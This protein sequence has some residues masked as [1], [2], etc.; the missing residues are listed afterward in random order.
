MNN[1][2]CLILKLPLT[3]LSQRLRQMRL[4]HRKEAEQHIQA[5]HMTKTRK[6]QEKINE[7]KRVTSLFSLSSSSH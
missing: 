1:V 3:S 5:H 2:I 6:I 4:R 7:G